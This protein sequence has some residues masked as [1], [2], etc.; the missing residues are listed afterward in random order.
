M[1][2]LEL[3][4]LTALG[5]DFVRLPVDAGPFLAATPV[6]QRLL[7]DAL[8]NVVVRLL[9]HELAVLV[10]MHPA[11]YQSNWRPRDILGKNNETAFAAYEALLVTIAQRL[12][13]LP[14][15]DI[16]LELMNEPQ[17][18]C[19]KGAEDDWTTQ[20]VELYTAVRNSSPTLPI[21]LTGGCWS[22]VSG[23]DTLDPRVFDDATL[24]DIHFYDPHGFTHQSIP[25]S[26]VPTRYIAG[27]SYPAANGSIERTEQL[28]RKR[29]EILKSEGVDVPA[30]AFDDAR[31]EIRSY[32][33]RKK[34]DLRYIEER[35]SRI[36][37]WSEKYGIA[38]RRIVIGEFSAIRPPEGIPE[39]ESR[40]AWLKDVRVTAE[41]NGFAWALWDYFAGFG[42]LL[43]NETRAIDEQMAA[44]LGLNTRA[45]KP[46]TDQR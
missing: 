30:S 37:A 26:R 13:D 1:S 23:L 11:N 39:D 16:A 15:A 32:Y 22:S 14:P 20:Q 42:L 17:P 31:Q 36:T 38:P 45:L 34:P 21:V 33:H 41:A 3:E 43:D 46:R 29:I 19:W 25:W 44:A 27:L 8:R 24:Y 2:D 18:E 6:E 12:G 9:D 40:L 5:F 10:D 4:R 35:F 28:T 7:I